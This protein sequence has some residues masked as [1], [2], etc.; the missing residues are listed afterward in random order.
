MTYWEKSYVPKDV[1]NRV[2]AFL[3]TDADRIDIND[4]VVTSVAFDDGKTGDVTLQTL[5]GQHE[6]TMQLYSTS[7]QR[8]VSQIMPYRED[9]RID[10]AAVQFHGQV[11]SIS[12]SPAMEK[13]HK[14]GEDE[15]CVLFSHGGR[16]DMVLIKNHDRRFQNTLDARV[17]IWRANRHT[18]HPEQIIYG[19]L[20]AAGYELEKLPLTMVDLDNQ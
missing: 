12:M 14:S 15:R 16:Y 17:Q 11:Y 1:W 8:L 13:Q 18:V 5:K 20:V 10:Y 9:K 2:L 4:T 3:R 6:I 19:G 7:G